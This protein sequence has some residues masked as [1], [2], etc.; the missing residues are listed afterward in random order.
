MWIVYRA[1]LQD[2]PIFSFEM[3][4]YGHILEKRVF[5]EIFNL[6]PIRTQMHSLNEFLNESDC[7]IILFLQGVKMS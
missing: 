4:I 6:Q 3:T 2:L 5:E 7:N 1:K